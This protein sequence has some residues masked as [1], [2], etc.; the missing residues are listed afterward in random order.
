M[1]DL[2]LAGAREGAVLAMTPGLQMAGLVGYGRGTQR[3]MW[4]NATAGARNLGTLG[5]RS[6]RAYDVNAR[7]QV[8]GF[9]HNR[10]GAARAFIW[11]AR[12]GMLDLNRYLRHAPPGLVLDDALAIND[13]GAIVAT[14][15]AGLVLLTPDALC[16]CGLTLGPLEAPALVKAGV[17]LQAS[18]AFVDA[19]RIGA[20]S[21]TWSW[22][23]GSSGQAGTLSASGTAGKA[24]AGHS[25]AT[26]G[27]YRVTATVVDLRGRR[28][29]VAHDVVVTPPGGALAGAGE[30][31]SPPG[32]LRHAPWHTGKVSFRLLAPVGGLAQA[33]ATPGALQVDLPGLH[34]RSLDVGVLERQGAQQ[35]LEGSG[36]V[37][38]AGNYL[39]RLTSS[40]T[41]NA[42]APG[43]FA[44]KIW[45][46]DAAG[47]SEIVDYDNS[48]AAF[49]PGAA[50]LTQE[51]I[52]RD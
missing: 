51:S 18:V 50:I 47:K 39:F 29:A 36:T 37:R 24:S 45:H 6:S 8:V 12:S 21:V 16:S 30:L 41:L 14:G 15:N 32:A 40:A 19:E 22:G 25:F 1:V 3:A 28:L 33:R 43:R 5:G 52:V 34:F 10:A 44:L 4:W 2:G 17:P 35:V 46:T 11:T 13:S 49:D 9:A 38:G 48:H 42:G 20:R 31:M 7:A 26:P 23:D 27:L